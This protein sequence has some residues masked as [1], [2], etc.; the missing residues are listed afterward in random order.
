MTDVCD[1]CGGFVDPLA[2]ACIRCGLESRDIKDMKLVREKGDTISFGGTGVLDS[3]LGDKSGQLTKSSRPRG[4]PCLIC[5]EWFKKE[6]ERF[7][8]EAYGGFN[9]N[10]SGHEI[11]GSNLV[12]FVKRQ[13]LYGGYDSIKGQYVI[14]H[15]QSVH[16]VRYVKKTARGPIVVLLD[17]TTRMLSSYRIRTP[18][19]LK[20]STS[21][22]NLSKGKDD[23]L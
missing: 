4:Y 23:E 3:Q 11:A 8:L 9:I 5:A 6:D 14:G 19:M 16:N 17:G 18:D 10:T 2:L 1:E 21:G 12:S 20:Y 22:N 13:D 7:A 15:Y